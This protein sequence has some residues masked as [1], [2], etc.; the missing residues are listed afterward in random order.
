MRLIPLLLL[1]AC[2][3]GNGGSAVVLDTGTDPDDTGT[4]GLPGADDDND[5][6]SE[7]DGDCDDGQPAVNPMATDIVGDGID[8]NC[9]GADG[10]DADGDGHADAASGGDDCD[11]EDPYTFPGAIEIWYD[12]KAQGCEVGPTEPW[13]DGDQDGDGHA[14]DFVDGDDCLDTDADVHPDAFDWDDGIDNNCNGVTDGF[15]FAMTWTG[16][17]DYPLTVSATDI[18]DVGLLQVEDTEGNILMISVYVDEETSIP[19]FN[20]GIT[21]PAADQ[22][23]ELSVEGVCFAW[24]YDPDSVDPTGDCS[25]DDPT[26]L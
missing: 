24:G 9:D 10:F 7:D 12:G 26:A 14:S 11:D 3:S 1:A 17:P 25:R 19:V 18:T 13:D 6:Y 8:Q 23:Y 4:V 22:T 20:T 5:G 16:D 15:S 2:G 21:S